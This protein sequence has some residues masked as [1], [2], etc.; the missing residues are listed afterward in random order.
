MRCK[1]AVGL[2]R[3]VERRYFHEVGARADDVEYFHENGG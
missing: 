2:K 3:A 1:A